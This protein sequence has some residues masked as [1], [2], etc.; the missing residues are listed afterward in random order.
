VPVRERASTQPP[1]LALRCQLLVLADVI[2]VVDR[3]DSLRKLVPSEQAYASLVLLDALE[4]L[5]KLRNQRSLAGLET[6]AS[7]DAPEKI[8]IRPVPII[9]GK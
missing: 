6:A 1:S 3:K 2:E 9:H 7:H 8:A 4:S 5:F